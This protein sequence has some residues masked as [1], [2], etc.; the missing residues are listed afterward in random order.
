E[1]ADVAQRQGQRNQRRNGHGLAGQNAGL[2]PARSRIGG[3]RKEQRDRGHHEDQVLLAG[4]KQ[5][6]GQ[7]QQPGRTHGRPNR[8]GQEQQNE[9]FGKTG[10]QE[11][12]E[13]WAEK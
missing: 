11:Y 9:R 4:Q 3:R 1:P 10:L 7:R 6:Q 8:G 2:S 13:P 5:P 12:T